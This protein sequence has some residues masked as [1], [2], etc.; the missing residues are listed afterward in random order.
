MVYGLNLP[1]CLSV[2]AMYI[3]HHLLYIFFLPKLHMMSSHCPVHNLTS[4][5]CCGDISPIY[6]VCPYQESRVRPAD[7][8]LT[9]FF[10]DLVLNNCKVGTPDTTASGIR[11]G[12]IMAGF[13]NPLDGIPVKTALEGATRTVGKGEGNQRKDPFTTIMA[14]EVVTLYGDS[15]NLVTS[16]QHCLM[17]VILCRISSD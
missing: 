2:C 17:F 5:R 12:H 13:A 6:R 8:Y 7:T 11:W 15:G 16:S 3:S 14:K 1:V 10:N 9:L 4:V